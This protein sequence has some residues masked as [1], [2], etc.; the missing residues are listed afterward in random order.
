MIHFPVEQPARLT[1]C[2]QMLTGSSAGMESGGQLNPAHS[3]WL[4][5]L[6]QEWDLAAPIGAARQ[7]KKKKATE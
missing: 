7:A 5:G 3:R 4:M 2:G 1:V 6:P